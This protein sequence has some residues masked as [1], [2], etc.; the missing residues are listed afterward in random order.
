[1]SDDLHDDTELEEG[2]VIDAPE[3]TEDEDE[4]FGV[5]AKEEDLEENG[6]HKLDEEEPEAGE[7]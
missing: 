6:F 3:G 1:M 2:A 4:L 5:N 7:F